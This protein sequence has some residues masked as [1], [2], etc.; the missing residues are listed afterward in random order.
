MLEEVDSDM[1]PCL[2]PGFKGIQG[3]FV[4]SDREKESYV[5][6]P[7]IKDDAE[8]N[9]CKITDL[10][11]G[12]ATS[13]AVAAIREIAG[14]E[15]VNNR[16]SDIVVDIEVKYSSEKRS[17]VLKGIIGKT[18]SRFSNQLNLLDD[19]RCLVKFDNE[20]QIIEA[21]ARI[22]IEVCTRARENSL[23]VL[24]EQHELADAKKKFVEAVVQG[25]LSISTASS[26][27]RNVEDIR[28]DVARILGQDATDKYFERCIAMRFSSFTS[29][30]VNELD[31]EITKLQC[32]IRE[33]ESTT[34]RQ[35]AV[36]RA[37]KA[38]ETFA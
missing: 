7:V 8:T 36:C 3:K 24:R 38:C 23:V 29:E 34:P 4:A 33:V 22:R 37:K 2:V 25:E 9:S 31:A 5:S 10:G 27:P 21:F 1:L 15:E 11:V 17:D 26:R 35:M 28:R 6:L 18:T 30:K 12:V 19:K 32:K 13:T 16:S 20:N 14:V